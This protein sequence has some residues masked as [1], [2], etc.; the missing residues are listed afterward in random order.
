MSLVPWAVHIMDGVLTDPW[1][2]GGYVLAGVLF[3]LAA[4]RVHDDEVARIGVLT[5]AFFVISLARVPLGP[6]SVHLLGNGLVGVLLGRRAAL[7]IG[8]GL[9]L[10]CALLGHGGYGT[11]GVNTCVLTLP[12]LLAGQ[13]FAGLRRL[14]WVRHPGFRAGLVA[15]CALVWILSLVYS[16]AL[17]LSN[18]VGRLTSLNTAWADAVTLHPATLTAAGLLAGLAAWAER[19]LENGPDFQLGLVVG[20]VA[21]LATLLLNGFVL[22]YGG[23]EDWHTLVLLTFVAHLPIAALEGFVVGFAVGFLARVKP[24]MLG[25][26]SGYPLPPREAAGRTSETPPGPSP[27]EA[28][29]RC[30]RSD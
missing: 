2:A 19:R 25:G 9:F 4:W 20:E 24:E 5:A 28:V 17:L 29:T 30:R 13:L 21:V 3:L 22:L 26:E 11:L 15:A 10:Q 16:V 18:P 27:G 12:A 23:Q 1:H 8:V 6:T 7:S 14:P